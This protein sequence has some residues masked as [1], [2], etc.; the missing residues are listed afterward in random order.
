MSTIE[1]DAPSH[2]GTTIAELIKRHAEAFAAWGRAADEHEKVT[3]IREQAYER[4]QAIEAAIVATPAR[5]WREVQAK[6]KLAGSKDFDRD[7]ID[8]LRASIVSDVEA[9]TAKRA[10]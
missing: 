5:G 8:D 10:A 3:L 7:H 6:T 1:A 9:L 2:E 4:L